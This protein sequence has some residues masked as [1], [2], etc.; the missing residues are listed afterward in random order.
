MRLA[1]EW[2]VMLVPFGGGTNVTH[3]L[4]IYPT[5]KRMVISVDMARMNKI[6]WVDKENG[7]ACI[8]AGK[9]GYDLERDLAQYGVLSG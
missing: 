9:I 1:V 4:L 5:E 6:L 8:Q 7:L 3:S 2:G